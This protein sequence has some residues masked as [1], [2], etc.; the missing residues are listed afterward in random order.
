MTQAVDPARAA[1]ATPLGAPGS[2]RLRYGA[3]MTL[4]QAGELTAEVLEAYRIASPLDAE[5]PA[6]ILAARDLPA[7]G[8]GA[9]ADLIA[10]VDG[11]LASLPGP[12]PAAVR[13]GLAQATPVLP[14]PAATPV[15]VIHLP[16]AL[17]AL[18]TAFA[19]ATPWLNW[20]AFAGYDRA[21]IGTAFAGG[22]AFAPLAT[23][24]DYELGLFL[25]APRT[26]YRDHAHAAPELYLPLT[27][28][29]R[30]RFAPGAAWDTQPAQT[31]VWNDPHAPHAMLT[32]DLPFLSLYGWTRDVN[33]PAYV[34]DAPDWPEW[35]P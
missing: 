1:L 14:T 23:G 20:T 10:A 32:G 12:G 25:I 30:W 35:E 26:L 2:G 17:A 16:A 21:R 29:H 34:I 11:M 6:T 13:A 27:G 18:P 19:A 33:E 31:P 15:T 28:P 9:I 5:N 8:A 7:P 24:A 22:N 3:A 4:Y